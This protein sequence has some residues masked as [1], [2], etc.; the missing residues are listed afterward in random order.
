MNAIELGP[1][2]FATERL[3]FL[4]AA[5]TFFMVFHLLT[6]WQIAGVR[7]DARAWAFP[8][9]MIWLLGARSGYV[10]QQWDV[11]SEHPLD[12]LKL[13]QGGVSVWAG[14]AGLAAFAILAYILR[15][16]A[17]APLLA[18]AFAGGLASLGVL[19]LKDTDETATLPTTAFPTMAGDFTHL[20]ERDGAPL[21]LNLW[22]SWCPPCRREMPMMMD[23]A[24]TVQGA[25]LVFA[26][27][28]ETTAQVAGFLDTLDLGGRHVSLDP[29]SSLM[30]RFDAV[31][32]PTTLF[33][34]A[35]GTLQNVHFGEI[36][37][38]N[39]LSQ[40]ATIDTGSPELGEGDMPDPDQTGDPN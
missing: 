23:V 27:Q 12:I 4:L 14:F 25:D 21:I 17:V 10:V 40:I 31:G 38:A 30:A 15:R 32:L 1:F 22:A 11:F 37:R 28:G 35:S 5:V 6:L 9:A 13:W 18:A 29:T 19:S 8:A 3:A 34:D 36:S 39:L 26:N 7:K 33:F 2:V 24:N 16:G 20:N